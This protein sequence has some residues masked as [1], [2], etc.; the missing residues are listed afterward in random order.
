MS[1]RAALAAGRAAHDR[2]MS[3]TCTITRPDIEPSWDPVTGTYTEVEPTE[4]YSG[5]CRVKP[6]SRTSEADVGARDVLVA[7][8]DVALPHGTAV[9][10]DIGDTLTVTASSDTWLIDRPLVVSAV[11][12]GSARTARRLTVDDRRG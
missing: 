4:L 11:E 6:V 8:Y 12:L 9:Q 2:L 10:I 5:L 3:D 7:R 1:D